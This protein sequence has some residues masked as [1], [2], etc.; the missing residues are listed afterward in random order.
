[1][2]DISEIRKHIDRID[3]DILELFKE[4]MDVANEV[5][6][7]KG[8][9]K[10]PV[11]DRNREHQILVNA[12]AKVPEDQQAYVQVLMSLLME[13]SRSRQTS[14]LG[15]SNQVVSNINKAIK[16]SP[17]LFPR[18]AFVACQ[19]V[20]GAYS[21]I[22]TDRL[23][24]HAN[25]SYFDTFDGVFRAV[26]QGFSDYGVLPIENSSAGS[27]NEVYDL[28][29]QYDFHI[30]RT[31]RLKVDH[32]LLAKPGTKLEDIREIYSH[33][34]AVAQSMGFLQSLPNA[35]VHVV[36]NTAVASKL[37]A[38]SERSD[39]AALA[40]RACAE[41][42]GLVPLA[43]AVQDRDDNYTRFACITK[44]LT[45][46]PSADRSSLM[47]VVGN[48]P[49]ALFKVLA[50]FY[51][52]DINIIKLESRPI[53]GKDFEFMFYFDVDCPVVAPEFTQLMSTLGNVCEDMRY[54][55]SY[56][57]VI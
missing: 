6:A 56:S 40:S 52:L 10:L 27:V 18:D 33:E 49:G 15:R 12:A 45:I 14:S 42:Y 57:E 3:N 43:Q 55:G 26:D 37:V 29:M 2:A 28:M 24:K 20:E 31:C 50:K 13:A 48:E 17:E 11:F 53:P 32:N 9:H 22:A 34:Q 5:A 21:Q 16:E 19:G 44:K 25:I 35:Q 38:N 4:R 46:Y 23:F 36:E 30:V 41:L 7:Y 1:M 51:A 8:E 47:L 54:L 39:V